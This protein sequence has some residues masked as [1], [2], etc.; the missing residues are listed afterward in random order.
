MNFSFFRKPGNE[1]AER[2]TDLTVVNHQLL[3]GVSEAHDLRHRRV[4]YQICTVKQLK[5]G[6]F[7]FNQID[8]VRKLGR[9]LVRVSFDPLKRPLLSMLII[10]TA[11][12]HYRLQDG[13][14]IIIG[15]LVNSGL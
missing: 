13:A 9:N 6:L 8:G 2:T 7:V 4:H 5:R 1:V 14:N 3:F 10:N 11:P 15:T 12:M